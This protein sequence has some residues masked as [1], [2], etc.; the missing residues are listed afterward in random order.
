MILIRDMQLSTATFQ[1]SFNPGTYTVTYTKLR[2][3]DG[4]GGGV[5]AAG[6]DLTKNTPIVA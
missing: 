5:V 3:A 4:Q 2:C 6:W 1:I